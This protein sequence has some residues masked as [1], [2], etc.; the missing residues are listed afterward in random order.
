MWH[1]ETDLGERLRTMSV[2]GTSSDGAIQATVTGENR[3]ELRFRARTYQWYDDRGLARQLSALGTS[4]W[5]V[6][7]RRRAE[8]TR[9][10][11]GQS[12]GE[13]EQNR[14]R[15]GDPRAQ[16][17]A[18]EL[19]ELGC[20]GISPGGCVH[21]RLTGATRWQVEIVEGTVR[22]TSER[23]FVQEAVSAFDA[24]IRDRTAK[25]A[26]LRG[27]YF[28]IGVP[29]NWIDQAGPDGAWISRRSG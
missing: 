15:A 20:E 14:R 12:R 17:F 27:E 19:Q 29:R 24:V 23:F 26:L 1:Q 21:L 18:E 3:L 6:W 10:A 9:L 7:T 8:I 5:V 2:T 28:D 4:T 22:D 13:A 11:L 16:R 25:L